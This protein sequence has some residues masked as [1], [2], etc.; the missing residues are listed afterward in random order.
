M[1]NNDMSI[2]L[3]TNNNKRIKIIDIHKYL[4]E[5]KLLSKFV[6]E[7]EILFEYGSI[8]PSPSK[9]YGHIEINF[10][11]VIIRWWKITLR[12]IEGS[13]YPCQIRNNYEDFSNDEIAQREICRIFGKEILDYCLNIIYGNIDW[14]KYL[15]LN[16]KIKIF[17]YVNLDDIPRISSVSKLFRSISRHNDLWKIFYI[18]QHGYQLFKNKYFIHLAKIYGWRRLFFTNKLKLQMELRRQSLSIYHHQQHSLDFDNQK[19]FQTT[20]SDIIREKE[21]KE[22]EEEQQ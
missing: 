6:G 1:E 3:Y 22:K 15:P 2:S 13:I 4:K 21:K 19:Q 9:D 5:H 16:I 12:N 7:N 10:N 14:F 8:A 11:E 18:R 20:T 17:S